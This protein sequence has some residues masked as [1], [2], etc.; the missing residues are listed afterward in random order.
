MYPQG[1]L[2]GPIEKVIDEFESESRSRHARDP[3]APLYKVVA[4]QHAERSGSTRFILASAGGTPPDVVCGEQAII[5]DW[6]ARGAFLPLDEFVAIDTRAGIPDSPRPERYYRGCTQSVC[7]RGRMYG[8]P[9]GVGNSALFYNKDLLEE[10][11]LAYATG[12]LRGQAKPP[13]TW[14]EV[15]EYCRRLTE[16]EP[17]RPGQP[18]KVGFAPLLGAGSL[19][20]YAYLN[21]GG[22]LT[23][24]AS[25]CTLNDPRTQEAMEFIAELYTRQGGVAK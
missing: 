17:D 10:A 4:G 23:P 20:V 25:T 18:R 9:L 14:D 5:S 1:S 22:L 16:W 11:G 24:D 12:P 21:D 3:A 13:A 2:T 15:L 7:Y 8:V 19:E 6:M